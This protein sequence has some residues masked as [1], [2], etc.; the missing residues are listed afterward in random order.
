MPEP[1]S[2]PRSGVGLVRSTDDAVE[3]RDVSRE[4][5]S[6]EGSLASARRAGHGAGSPF[7]PG[8]HG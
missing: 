1:L 5:A 8:S 2:E 6:P 3:G 7:H 4:G